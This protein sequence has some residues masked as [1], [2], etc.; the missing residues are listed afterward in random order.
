[1]I[2]RREGFDVPGID[3]IVEKLIKMKE[4]L[5]QLRSIKPDS[6]NA[7]LKDTTSKYAIERLMQLIV[8]LA[9]DINNILLSYHKKPPAPD[10][11]NS[12]IE[13]VECGVWEESFAMGIAPSTGLRNRLVHEYETINNEVVYKSVDKVIEM[14]TGYIIR[15]NKYIQG[16]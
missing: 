7:Y 15:V 10:Y 14:Y 16:K 13:L 8:D 6:Y 12:F 3:T 11:F 2:N 4:Y 5:E 9:L 1:L